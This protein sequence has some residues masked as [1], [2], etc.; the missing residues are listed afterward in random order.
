MYI[1]ETMQIHQPLLE[2]FPSKDSNTAVQN[3]SQEAQTKKSLPQDQSTT[4]SLRTWHLARKMLP[5]TLNLRCSTKIRNEKTLASW[6]RSQG[7]KRH[8]L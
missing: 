6:Q 3:K 5:P 4:T 1:P 2:V 8:D 7:H